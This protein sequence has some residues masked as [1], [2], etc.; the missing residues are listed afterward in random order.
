[1]K[2]VC[3]HIPGSHSDSKQVRDKKYSQMCQTRIL[4]ELFFQVD[5]K[6][7]LASL[8]LAKTLVE[9]NVENARQFIE[10][11]GLMK[12]IDINQSIHYSDKLKKATGQVR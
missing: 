12:L 5:E 2:E 9:Y 11:K 10:H 1:M 7:A 4:F 3:T 8:F 6:P